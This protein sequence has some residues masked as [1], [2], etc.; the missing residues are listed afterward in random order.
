[1][2]SLPYAITRPIVEQVFKNYDGV[3]KVDGEVG[4]K[5]TYEL[6]TYLALLES[7]MAKRVKQVVIELKGV[8]TTLFNV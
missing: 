2:S 3:L 1:V 7:S 8:G 5:K 4:K 6:C